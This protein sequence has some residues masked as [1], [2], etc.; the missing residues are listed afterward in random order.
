M[1][2]FVINS[3]AKQDRAYKE[4]FAVKQFGYSCE[5]CA[6][7]NLLNIPCHRCPVREAHLRAVMEIRKGERKVP[8]YRKFRED[9]SQEIITDRNGHKTY[10]LVDCNVNFY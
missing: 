8:V 4:E 7:R 3:I 2:K 6:S 5:M 1:N 10:I 9:K